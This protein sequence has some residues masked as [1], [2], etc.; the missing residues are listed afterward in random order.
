MQHALCSYRHSKFVVASRKGFQ[1]GLYVVCSWCVCAVIQA[2][3]ST[4]TYVPLKEGLREWFALRLVRLDATA[5]EP[6]AAVVCV[7]GDVMHESCCESVSGWMCLGL[8]PTLL[9]FGGKCVDMTGPRECPCRGVG[10]N[11]KAWRQSM[12]GREIGVVVV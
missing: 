6:A 9:H 10:C 2:K 3:H 7:A 4:G 11:A 1:H 5:A 12:V 8:S